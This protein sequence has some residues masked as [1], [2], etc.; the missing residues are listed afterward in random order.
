M[1]IET[2]VPIIA[3]TA[4]SMMF[5]ETRWLGVVAI[6]AISYFYPVMFLVTAVLAVAGYF[7]WRFR[8]DK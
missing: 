2:I 7:C 6:G 3:I 1:A 4:V 5:K 8:P